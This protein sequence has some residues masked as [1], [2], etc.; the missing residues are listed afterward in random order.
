[1]APVVRAMTVSE[2]QA[3]KEKEANWRMRSAGGDAEGAGLGEHEI[4]EAAVGDEDALGAA[5]GAGGI[6]DISELVGGWCGQVGCR[7]RVRRPGARSRS[8]QRVAPGRGAA[9]AGHRPDGAL[10]EDEAR[11]PSRRA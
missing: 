6:D 5:G 2:T 7:A 1:M 4:G 3:S 8:R 10:G 11:R 9:R